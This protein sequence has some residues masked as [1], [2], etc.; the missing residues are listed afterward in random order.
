MTLHG[1]RTC[2]TCRKALAALRDS[3]RDVTFRDIRADPLTRAELERV[4]AA[5]GDGIIN[6]RSKTWA[7]LAVSERAEDPLALVARHPALMK[8][9]LIEA[10]GALHLG[11]DRQVQRALLGGS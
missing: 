11:W 1:L 2:D 8:R 6:R 7:G 10:E 5:L 3:G 9:P 4:Y